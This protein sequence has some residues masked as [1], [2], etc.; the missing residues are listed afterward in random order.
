MPSKHYY[1][2]AL[3]DS[4]NGQRAGIVVYEATDTDILDVSGIDK[5]LDGGTL[6]VARLVRLR[7]I[8]H[9]QFNP[10]PEEE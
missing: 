1:A 5:V 3:Q 2:R 7:G 10:D 9:S 4:E 6:D 8:L